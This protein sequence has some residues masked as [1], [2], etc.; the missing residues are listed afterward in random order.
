MTL[1]CNNKAPFKRKP[2]AVL[3]DIDN[4][5]YPYAPAHKAAME[6]VA[7]K[8]DNLLGLDQ[9]DF[10][11]A[12]DKARTAIK[13]RLGGTAACH[14]RLLYMQQTLELL[15]LKTQL[16]MALDFEQTYWRTFLSSAALFLGVKE[17][18]Q[19][20]RRAG[21]ATCAVTDLGAQIQFRKLIYFGL[22][23]YF[24]FVVT[25]EE[26]GAEK[27]AA[28]PFKLALD[29]LGASPDEVFMIGDE[30]ATDILGAKS[31]GIAAVQKR[32][33]GIQVF[34]D[35]RE[36]DIVFENFPELAKHLAIYGWI[37]SAA[38]KA[39]RK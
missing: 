6:A 29:K 11:D 9:K 4:T 34:S 10:L 30:A 22:N 37:E 1:T 8:A 32:H 18:F 28:A 5:L 13:A 31:A 7:D 12:F 14:S 38:K 26:A 21:I 35:K 15:G 16:Y 19:A 39:V 23:D 25:S 27:P 36:P 3:F 2:K 24:D 17:F 33:N 20:L